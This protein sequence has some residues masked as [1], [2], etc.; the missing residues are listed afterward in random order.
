[1][2]E[3]IYK[4]KFNHLLLI[5][6]LTAASSLIFVNM[7]LEFQ[8]DSR[9]EII[10][11]IP[12]S[13]CTLIGQFNFISNNISTWIDSWSKLFK[14]KDIVIATPSDSSHPYPKL[15]PARYIFYKSDKGYHSPYINIG[16]VIRENSQVRAVLYVHDD[17]LITA[18]LWEYIG[19]TTW[20][21][22]TQFWW[23]YDVIRLYKNGTISTNNTLLQSWP[24]WSGC[25]KAFNKILDDRDIS[26]YLHESKTEDSF[27]NVRLGQSDMLYAYFP[28]FEQKEYFWK[29]LNLFSKYELFLECALPTAVLMM[30]QKFGIE[31]HNAALCTS[32]QYG[33]V[34]SNP[35]LLIQ[36]CT[37]EDHDYEAYHPIKLGTSSNWSLYFNKL[38]NL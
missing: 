24:S 21:V 8:T 38:M 25:H 4:L 6:T 30:Q 27:I 23:G 17:M 3:N 9:P 34:R 29:L 7:Y 37:E 16:K 13:N 28:N 2:K 20:V 32:W 22:T 15:T 5:Y 19:S 11:Y 18:S 12:Y 36:N 14:L 1:M 31:V 26:P 33:T 10:P 35:D